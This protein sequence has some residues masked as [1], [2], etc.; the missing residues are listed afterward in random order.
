MPKKN[1]KIRITIKRLITFAKY[2][3]KRR[4]YM[5]SLKLTL[6][7]SKIIPIF[8]KI[9]YTFKYYIEITIKRNLRGKKTWLISRM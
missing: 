6:E 5:N 2:A 7:K 3:L 1:K 8:L 9:G 4:R